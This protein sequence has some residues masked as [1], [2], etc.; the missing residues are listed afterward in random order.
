[1]VILHKYLELPEVIMDF[2]TALSST[3]HNLQHPWEVLNDARLGEKKN[4]NVPGA[5]EPGMLVCFQSEMQD[6][7]TPFF[8]SN[9][10]EAAD[11][12]MTRHI[13][14]PMIWFSDNTIWPY[15]WFS[16][17]QVKINLPVVD[18]REIKDI[19]HWANPHKATAQHSQQP[20]CRAFFGL[21]RWQ[22]HIW[23][24]DGF[25]AR[26]IQIYNPI[27]VDTIRQDMIWYTVYPYS[28]P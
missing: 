18:E 11:K 16:G 19:V 22:K 26:N 27:Q 10:R 3:L 1:M 14:S 17:S 28:Y 15:A 25:D 7:Y 8:V 9:F 5:W 24:D 21:L 13:F 20:L 23:S 12:H 6:G 4:V 2:R